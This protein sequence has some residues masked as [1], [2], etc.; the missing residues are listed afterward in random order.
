MSYGIILVTEEPRAGGIDI[1]ASG[2]ESWENFDTK[3]SSD[4]RVLKPTQC[5]EGY[6][7]CSGEGGSQARSKRRLSKTTD[8]CH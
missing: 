7:S 4:A 3:N 5:S 6:I 8:G 2:R 1:L